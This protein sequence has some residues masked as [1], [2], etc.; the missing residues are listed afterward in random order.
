MKYKLKP[1]AKLRIFGCYEGLPLDKWEQ[2]NHGEAVELTDK[3]LV[4][5]KDKVVAATAKGV[6]D[7]D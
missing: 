2:L 3:E 1:G 4:R 6:K 5:I 7:G